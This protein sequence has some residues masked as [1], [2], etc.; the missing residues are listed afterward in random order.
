MD[1][2]A[3]DQES[4]DDDQD[5]ELDLWEGQFQFVGPEEYSPTSGDDPIEGS[6]ELYPNQPPSGDNGVTKTSAHVWVHD[7]S[8]QVRAVGVLLLIIFNQNR[9]N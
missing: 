7:I 1:A 5:L 6:V 8:N 3:D 4:Q 2:L 9:P